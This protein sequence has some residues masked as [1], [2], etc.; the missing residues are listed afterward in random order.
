MK[1]ALW[2]RGITA[3]L[4]F[5][6]TA[7]NVLNVNSERYRKMLINFL[8]PELDYIDVHLSLWLAM[9]IGHEDPAI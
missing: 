6:N 8:W 3:S 5:E 9:K 1:R 2:A 7:G 4:L